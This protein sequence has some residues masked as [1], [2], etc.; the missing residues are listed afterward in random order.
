MK[1]RVNTNFGDVTLPAASA[2]TLADDNTVT[3]FLHGHCHSLALAIHERMGWQLIGLYNETRPTNQSPN[4]TVVRMPNK[5]LLDIT[6]YLVGTG[7][8]KVAKPIT[9]DE[10]LKWDDYR[11]PNIKMAQPF[12][13]VLLQTVKLRTKKVSKQMSFGY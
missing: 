12:A 2:A 1:M 10:I 9:K 3:A 8:Y 5:R 13:D 4:H 6:G 11:K 7:G